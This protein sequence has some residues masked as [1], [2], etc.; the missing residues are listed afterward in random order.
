MGQST[1]S[2]GPF[3]IANCWY[4]QRIIH[5]CSKPPTSHHTIRQI[6]VSTSCRDGCEE[7][8]PFS[9]TSPVCFLFGSLVRLELK[10]KFR[11]GPQVIFLVSICFN[12]KLV[13]GLSLD[14]AI[15]GNPLHAL[16]QLRRFELEAGPFRLMIY[17][18]HMMIFHRKPWNC[19]RMTSFMSPHPTP[20]TLKVISAYP[21]WKS[22]YI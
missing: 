6:R 5:S 10:P 19:Q 12:T 1:I 9:P 21:S 18:W 15:L 14:A 8:P 13:T 20:T 7:F 2:T 3:S 4:N 11:W 22:T 16:W 17:P